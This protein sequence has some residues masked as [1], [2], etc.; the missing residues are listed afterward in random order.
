MEPITINLSDFSEFSTQLGP[1]G[2]VLGHSLAALFFGVIA[3]RQSGFA[4]KCYGDSCS[5]MNNAQSRDEKKQEM[6]GKAHSVR[7]IVSSV[8]GAINVIIVI[9]MSASLF[10]KSLDQTTSSRHETMSMIKSTVKQF[11]ADSPTIFIAGPYMMKGSDGKK[12][13][14]STQHPLTMESFHE[15]KMLTAGIRCFEEAGCLH[16]Y[17]ARC[18]GEGIQIRSII[19]TNEEGDF[20]M[21]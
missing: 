7:A 4:G 20:E 17:L 16:D 18:E 8:I 10:E 19:T 11:M 14:I 12:L 1:Y 15:L 21:K 13:A 5:D 2:Y 6:V 9:V 3:W